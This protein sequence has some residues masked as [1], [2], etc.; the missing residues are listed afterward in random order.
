MRLFPQQFLVR[1]FSSQLGLTVRGV[2]FL[3]GMG[4]LAGCGGGVIATP[5]DITGSALVGSVHGGQQPVT[6]SH[7]ALYATTSAGYQGTPNLLASTTTDGNGNWTISTAYTCPAGQQ[8]YVVASGGNPGIMG[9]VDNSAIFL[10]AALGPCAG[11]SS[12][13]F[14]NINEVTTVAA[15]YALAGFAPTGGAGFAEGN[16]TAGFTT[17]STNTQGLKDA[18]A[19]TA[20]LASSSAGT[21]LAVPSSTTFGVAPQAMMN[22]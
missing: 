21:A 16:I 19:N 18:F 20:N 7:I 5:A 13:T 10:V 17:S 11:V 4:G 3:G 1:K 22:T 15:A 14:V 9:T 12:S 8:A 6:S 2:A